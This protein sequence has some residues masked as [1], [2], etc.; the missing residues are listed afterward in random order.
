[1]TKT[2]LARAGESLA[3]DHLGSLGF[4]IVAQNLRLGRGEL[5]LVARHGNTLVFVEVKTRSG[6]DFG[7]PLEAVTPA[8]QRALRALAARYL[9]E[10]P[11]YGPVRFDCI[12]ILWGDPPQLEHLQ[13][14][15]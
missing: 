11:H 15:F 10:N 4:A 7:L 13:A 2:E 8:K 14:A 12:G 5:D 3:R 6:L 1:M 9:A